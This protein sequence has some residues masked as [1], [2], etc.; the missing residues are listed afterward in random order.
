M[1]GGT[2]NN[3]RT[4]T[5]ERGGSF[6]IVAR[7]RP[8]Q[9]TLV[10]TKH[11]EILSLLLLSFI[12]SVCRIY[13]CYNSFLTGCTNKN[14]ITCAKFHTMLKDISAAFDACLTDSIKNICFI[15]L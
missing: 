13:I 3:F 7:R 5:L 10:A 1:G 6:S 9:S 2:T 11:Y 4:C 12:V 8:M 14:F 15:I